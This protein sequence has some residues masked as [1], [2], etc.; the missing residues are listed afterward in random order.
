MRM[1]TQ[2]QK[3]TYEIEK[4]DG[5][6]SHGAYLNIKGVDYVYRKFSMID[7]EFI[8]FALSAHNALNNAVFITPNVVYV[9][10]DEPEFKKHYAVC[11]LKDYVPTN[12]G[13]TQSLDNRQNAVLLTHVK[14]I[15]MI[16]D[17]VSIE[18]YEKI[19]P[20]QEPLKNLQTELYGELENRFKV[21]VPPH[22]RKIVL[23]PINTSKIQTIQLYAQFYDIP[24]NHIL[25]IGNDNN[26]L[27]MLASTGYSVVVKG[28]TKP[29]LK[30]ARCISTKTNNENAVANI[31][32]RVIT[33][34]Y[35]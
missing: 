8:L 4:M 35:M 19:H 31:I 33:G 22:R 25:S 16:G 9:F 11:G 26:D 30:V 7:I 10:N 12:A 14:D 2:K 6:Y 32:F 20:Q 34:R 24:L 18:I 17:I 21:Y 27:E 5:V 1:F 28:S 15:L 13:I 3:D 29:A 23:S